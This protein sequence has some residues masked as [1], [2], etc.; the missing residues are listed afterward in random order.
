MIKQ[1]IDTL[2]NQD[3]TRKEFLQ[4][5]G[6]AL[7]V[8]FGITNLLKSLFEHNQRPQQSSALDYGGSAYGGAAKKSIL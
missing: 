4:Y 5:I 8:A 6:G 1:H 7:L 2:F 3:M